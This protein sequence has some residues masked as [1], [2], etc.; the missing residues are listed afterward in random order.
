MHHWSIIH[1]AVARVVAIGLYCQ[2][3]RFRLFGATISCPR[4]HA[5]CHG[6]GTH[7]HSTHGIIETLQKCKVQGSSCPVLLLH[8]HGIA[9]AWLA[10]VRWSFVIA[11]FI[12]LHSGDE[13]MDPSLQ[14]LQ[15]LASLVRAWAAADQKRGPIHIAL[16]L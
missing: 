4:W 1:N 13:W 11:C 14:V 5:T 6:P 7:S 10:P 16:R 8:G 12:L 9:L 2:L 3:V 15:V